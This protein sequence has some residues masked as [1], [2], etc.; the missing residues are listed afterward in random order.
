[1]K[2]HR[3]LREGHAAQIPPKGRM[4]AGM[5]NNGRSA[6]IGVDYRWWFMVIVLLVGASAFLFLPSLMLKTTLALPVAAVS[7][8]V[9]LVAW[10]RRGSWY[11]RA[12][13]SLFALTGIVLLAVTLSQPAKEFDTAPSAWRT[14]TACMLMGFAL[15]VGLLTS[16]E[17]RSRRAR[18][19]NGTSPFG[20][21]PATS[22]L[23]VA[24][25]EPAPVVAAPVAAATVAAVPEP[26]I[27]TETLERILA[28]H[29][30]ALA[31]V[32]GA[33][34][35][36]DTVIERV[37]ASVRAALNRLLTLAHAGD[38][39]AQ[40]AIDLAKQ[41]L[42]LSEVRMVL[43]Q[44]LDGPAAC[45]AS[46][47]R[48]AIGRELAGLLL[49]CSRTGEVQQRLQD[50]LAIVPQDSLAVDYLALCAELCG[51]AVQAERWYSQLLTYAAD[52][53]LKAGA[54][55]QLGLIYQTRDQL[56]KAEQMHRSALAIAE[57]LGRL[58]DVA[59]QL[60]Q[61]GAVHEMRGQVDLAGTMYRRALEIHEQLG[62]LEGMAN[63]YV[64]LGLLASQRDDLPAARDLYGRA[65]DLF[66]RA[67]LTGNARLVQQLLD[68]LVAS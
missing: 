44:I 26:E 52:P 55:S 39:A 25:A 24:I 37:R 61:L 17:S 47:E 1:M 5:T 65:R 28:H 42:D 29:K 18:Q 48:A 4:M 7:I 63:Q 3:G 59:N 15:M 53:A 58:E 54:Y 50:I 30:P 64:N 66:T 38:P 20:G 56:D 57:Q 51:D 27:D 22:R 35:S 43:A 13:A 60:G 67:G 6:P 33:M 34:L 23:P 21:E 45:A 12:S 31:H 62:R 2:D 11:R 10:L 14:A 8:A 19:T 41:S 68:E 36:P 16:L 40:T 46:D 49:L 32:G 9:A